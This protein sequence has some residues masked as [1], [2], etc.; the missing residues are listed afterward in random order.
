MYSTF[1]SE[2][3]W[4]QYLWKEGAMS[5]VDPTG[6][7]GALIALRSCLDWLGRPCLYPCTC[8]WM[9]ATLGRG[10]TGH[11]ARCSLLQLSAVLEG[12]AADTPAGGVT[13]PSLT[14]PAGS[15]GCPPQ[16]RLT[17][18]ARGGGRDILEA[19]TAEIQSNSG[20]TL[21]WVGLQLLH[22]D[23]REEGAWGGC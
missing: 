3:P 21:C 18:R 2:C 7:S 9:G 13:G 19:G 10:G 22:C 16:E 4:D 20:V 11:S 14:V 5:F 17:P 15:H 1:L 8:H 6:S 12:P 23:K